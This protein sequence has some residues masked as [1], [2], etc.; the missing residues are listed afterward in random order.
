MKNI[1]T[2]KEFSISLLEE[3]NNDYIDASLNK[4]EFIKRA[5]GN[6]NIEAAERIY[7]KKGDKINRDNFVNTISQLIY[8]EL[9][10]KTKNK[11]K[12]DAIGIWLK[13]EDD[14]IIDNSISL[15]TIQEIEKYD[16]DISAIYEL[17]KMTLPKDSE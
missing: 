16:K 5:S 6:I 7:T 3:S 15:N 17:V 1:N 14:T 13:F 12:I 4:K 9:I 11:Y 2:I 8:N 10:Q